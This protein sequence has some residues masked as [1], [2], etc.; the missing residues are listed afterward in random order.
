MYPPFYSLKISEAV[1]IALACRLKEKITGTILLKFKSFL[2][3]STIWLKAEEF[4][5]F[6]TN[7]ISYDKLWCLI[8]RLKQ[9]WL[10]L[11]LFQHATL[12]ITV[13]INTWFCLFS[14]H[15]VLMLL[16]VSIYY[17]GYGSSLTEQYFKLI[18]LPCSISSIKNVKAWH[19]PRILDY[20]RCVYQWAWLS[21]FSVQSIR[22]LLVYLNPNSKSGG[23]F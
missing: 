3:L 16:F 10:F 17:F 23:N 9:N 1:K 15:N 6:A 4:P 7:Y 12:P 14:F 19:E 2:V 18:N 11:S 5:W 8:T 13:S 20:I 22:I 21:K